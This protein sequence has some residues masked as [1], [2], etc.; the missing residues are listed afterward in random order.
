LRELSPAADPT[1][2]TYAARIRIDHPPP[3]VRLGM[4]ARVL[5]DLAGDSTLVVPLSAVVNVGNGPQVWVAQ[6]GKAVPRAVKVGQ[7]SETGAMIS[8][9]LQ[10][11]EQVIV[12]GTGKLVAGQAV[13]AKNVPLP[14]EQR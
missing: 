14:A 12:V 8:E 2:R 6:D 10:I 1:T 4:T 7:F 5:L 11:G 9:G 3:E 13:D